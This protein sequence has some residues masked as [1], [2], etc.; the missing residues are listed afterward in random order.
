MPWTA[1]AKCARETTS[2]HGT[3]PA[4]TISREWYASSTKAFSARI[5]C[6][7]PRLM[8]RQSAAGMIRGPRSIVSGR[9]RGPSSPVSSNVI[10]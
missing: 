7:R 1:R 6:A 2:S 8:T 3:I 4:R 5:R 9:S 10:P